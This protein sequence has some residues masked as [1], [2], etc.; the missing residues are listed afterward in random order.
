MREAD[1]MY[2]V[3]FALHIVCLGN[4]PCVCLR[5]EFGPAGCF[6]S[7]GHTAPHWIGREAPAAARCDKPL[8][9]P[10]KGPAGAQ[11]RREVRLT[12][13]LPTIC[14]GFVNTAMY[15]AC[16]NAGMSARWNS[17]ANT[18]NK[19]TA[20]QHILAFREVACKYVCMCVCMFV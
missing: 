7:E 9:L 19:D 10:K 15:C 4:E 5:L 8:Q 11:T 17:E 13:R 18:C 6:L 3:R 1:G 14:K 20:N 16:N 2:G 12:V